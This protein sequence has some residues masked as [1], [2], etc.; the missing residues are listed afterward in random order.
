VRVACTV[1]GIALALGSALPLRAGAGAQRSTPGTSSPTISAN[2]AGDRMPAAQQ[3]ALVQKHCAVCHTDAK[4]SGGLALERFDAAHAEPSVARMMLTKIT[5]DG[6]MTAAGVPMPD[7]A[8]FAAF[9]KALSS[10]AAE[11]VPG[12]GDWVVQVGLEGKGGYSLVKASI[13]REVDSETSERSAVYRL[14]LTCG[15]TSRTGAWSLETSWKDADGSS[16]PRAMPVA[17]DGSVPFSYRVDGGEEQSSALQPSGDH[18]A[19]ARSL[20]SFP[21]DVLTI[22]NLFA[23]ERVDFPLARLTPTVRRIF[24]WCFAGPPAG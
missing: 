20:A 14:A 21:A 18:S 16:A 10:A 1:M 22:S 24:A 19:S 23:G 9:T 11:D 15:A 5:E 8:T 4:P 7:A 12:D 13:A 2:A 3:N 6:A 17:G